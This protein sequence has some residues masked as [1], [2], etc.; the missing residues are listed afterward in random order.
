MFLSGEGLVYFILDRASDA[1]KIGYTT[2]DVMQR[3]RALQTGN[4]QG[5]EVLGCLSNQS[6]A[7]EAAIHALFKHLNISGGGTEWFRATPELLRFIGEH[8][9]VTMGSRFAWGWV[10]QFAVPL[11]VVGLLALIAYICWVR[12][13][14]IIEELEQ[15]L[16]V[17]GWTPA[18]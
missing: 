18:D 4:P 12:S 6:M 7:T 16:A 2:G 17:V 5:L 8:T 1:I 13:D 14:R 9:G 3:L 11:C 15:A 10:A